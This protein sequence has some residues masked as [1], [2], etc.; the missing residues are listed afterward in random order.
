MRGKFKIIAE[1]IR[2]GM[3][4]LGIGNINLILI[5]I[6]LIKD[7]EQEGITSPINLRWQMII[8]IERILRL[9]LNK[10]WV[11]SLIESH[12]KESII[13]KNLW[14]IPEKSQ[15]YIAENRD[16]IQNKVEW[17]VP[18]GKTLMDLNLLGL[19]RGNSLSSRNLKCSNKNWNPSINS[20][21]WTLTMIETI[22]YIHQE[23]YQHL[24]P[25]WDREASTP[26]HQYQQEC[27]PK[28]SRENKDKDSPRQ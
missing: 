17:E 14:I 15:K 18:Q 26:P 8:I 10:M 7:T 2:K 24:V 1:G 12:K 4:M 13:L 3:S 25:N 9:V 20:Q 16:L 19:L 6:N 23:M 21:E 5:K 27:Q 11:I 28:P 22:P